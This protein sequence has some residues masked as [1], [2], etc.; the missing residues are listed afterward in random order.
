MARDSTG[1]LVCRTFFPVQLFIEIRFIFC[2][3]GR[4]WWWPWS[5]LHQ[6]IWNYCRRK[7]RANGCLQ[8]YSSPCWVFLQCHQEPKVMFLFLLFCH[9]WGCWQSY[10]VGWACFKVVSPFNPTYFLGNIDGHLVD[11]S[12]SV[13]CL[14]SLCVCIQL[15]RRGLTATFAYNIAIA[16]RKLYLGEAV[17]ILQKY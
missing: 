3:I 2:I 13:Q 9:D 6:W 8:W 15:A 4:W 7:P 1:T 14:Q 12:E 17:S 5:R 11:M 16:C 10:L